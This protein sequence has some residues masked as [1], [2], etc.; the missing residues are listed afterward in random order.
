M[1]L[2]GK[3]CDRKQYG[4]VVWRAC[5]RAKIEPWTP[6]A[7][8]HLAATKI[9]SRYGIEAARV[10]LGHSDAGVTLIYAERD[11]EA[12]RKIAEEIG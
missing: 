1:N 11:L 7:L 3:P 9:R 8:R 4:M 10:A 12:F 6:N 5:K 2:R